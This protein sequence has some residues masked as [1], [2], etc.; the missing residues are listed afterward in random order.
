MMHPGL[1]IDILLDRSNGTIQWVLN[2]STDAPVLVR[3]SLTNQTSFVSAIWMKDD[4]E[5]MFVNPAKK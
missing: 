5:L 2:A 1:I 3:P 4:I